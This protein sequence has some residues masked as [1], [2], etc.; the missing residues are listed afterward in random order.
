MS[1]C[2]QTRMTCQFRLSSSR[3]VS[4]SRARF[5]CT[6]RSHQDPCVPGR[7]KW[8]GHPCQ[9]HPSMNTATRTDRKTT[10]ASRRS[11]RSGFVWTR[12]R[13]PL[14]H[15][16]R[17]SAIS[18]RVSR[19]GVP[20]IRLRV[21]SDEAGG[22]SEASGVV[23]RMAEWSRHSGGRARERGLSRVVTVRLSPAGMPRVLL[24]SR[25]APA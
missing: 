6:L 7:L 13:S 21:A 23:T 9:K 2:S 3:S 24:G 4:M 17:R 8:S 11:A 22:A 25:R 19:R 12:Y 18:G 10:S 1:S 14:A 20:C 5:L 15:S 16:C